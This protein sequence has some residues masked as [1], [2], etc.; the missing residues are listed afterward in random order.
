MVGARLITAFYHFFSDEFNFKT[1]TIFANVLIVS[2]LYPLYQLV[3]K[4][5]INLW[6][7]IPITGLLFAWNGNM[8]NYA[9]IGVLVHALS[10]IFLF[11]SLIIYHFKNIKN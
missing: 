9:L 3:K 8:D 5:K 4:A 2:I 1:A 10:L 7:F 11:F 6:H